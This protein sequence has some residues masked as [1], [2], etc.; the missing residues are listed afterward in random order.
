MLKLTSFNSS[1]FVFF[2]LLQK[3]ESN[4]KEL[5]KREKELQSLTEKLSARERVSCSTLNYLVHW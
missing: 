3:A 2:Y 1:F 4:R 5:E